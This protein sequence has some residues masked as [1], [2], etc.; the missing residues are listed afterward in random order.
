LRRMRGFISKN[1]YTQELLKQANCLSRASSMSIIEGLDKEYRVNKSLNPSERKE[2]VRHE[3]KLLS[4]GLSKHSKR[5]CEM[6][7][8]EIGRISPA[9]EA[10]VK[11]SIAHCTYYLENLD[12]FLAPK[13]IKTDAWKSGYVLDPLGVIY[14]IVPFNYPVWIA[15]KMLIP[16]L[17]T[18]NTVLI[19]PPNTGLQ[20][21][22]TLQDIFV[23]A[24]LKSVAVGLT[25]PDDTPA[26]M[27]HP[28]IQG[29][30]FTG[31]TASGHRIAEAAASNLK[32][33]VIELGGNDAFIVFQDA[34][35][36]LAVLIACV[37]RLANSGQ[38]CFSPKRYLLHESV[39]AEFIEKLK[40]KLETMTPGDPKVNGTRIGPLSAEHLV[41]RYKDQLQRAVNS[42]DKLLH[43]SLEPRKGCPYLFSPTIL[44][45]ADLNISPCFQEE[46]FG[47]NFS[48]TTFRTDDE[49]AELANNTQY[50]LGCTILTQDTEFGEGFSRRIDA[51]YTFVNDAVTSRSNLPAGGVKVSG[52]GRD[53][54]IHGVE[55][56]AN[57]KAFSIKK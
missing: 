25:D 35:L 29:V 53:C 9:S 24:G 50:G 36:D 32:R 10:E 13:L 5:L 15:F 56:F 47:P 16:T 55:S 45:V 26:I 20:I 4:H 8:T 22:E 7:T 37:T 51:G 19:R 14:K 49:A 42:G 31:S 12:S 17:L 33:S 30:S 2:K 41:A 1:P 18:G 52:Y 40:S 54:G 38:V 43:G 23:E 39:K 27:A 57:V 44:D 3:I 28:A 21:G 48:I 6:I 11:K 34:D 46:F